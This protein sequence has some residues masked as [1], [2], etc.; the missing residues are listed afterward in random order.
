MEEARIIQPEQPKPT[1][2]L[3]F[4]VYPLFNKIEVGEKGTFNIKGI[5]SMER[6][7]DGK[8][9]K[10]LRLSEIKINKVRE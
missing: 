7:E 3:N 6:L 10:T 8:T 9:L 2:T 5:I 1:I 4:S